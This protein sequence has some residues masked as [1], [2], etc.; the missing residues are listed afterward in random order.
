MAIY[1]P[2]VV[3]GSHAVFFDPHK[4]HLPTRDGINKPAGLITNFVKGKFEDQFRPH[5]RLFGFDMTKPFKGTLFRL[6]LR[7]EELS[8]KSKLRNKFYPKLEIR[9]LLQK[10]K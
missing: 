4:E 8:R 2:S 7:T 3:S 10:F 6:P 9:Q 5:T 1:L